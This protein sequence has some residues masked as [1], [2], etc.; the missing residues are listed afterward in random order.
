MRLTCSCRR[1]PRRRRRCCLRSCRRPTCIRR[2]HAAV[3]PPASAGSSQPPVHLHPQ[4][5][6]S[7]RSTCIRRLHAAAGPSA[8]QAAVGRPV[9][10]GFHAGG[11]SLA[12]SPYHPGMDHRTAALSAPYWPSGASCQLDIHEKVSLWEKIVP[13][14]WG[15]RFVAQIWQKSRIMNV[16]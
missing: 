3:G 2:L 12:Q 14:G 1:Q 4:A 16:A 9:S 11:Y 5:P 7:R 6:V 13:E 15:T 10:A 8:L